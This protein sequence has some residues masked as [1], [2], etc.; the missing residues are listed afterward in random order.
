M[1]ILIAVSLL[2]SSVPALARGGFF[3]SS[4]VFDLDC[5]DLAVFDGDNQFEC[6]SDEDLAVVKR[7]VVGPYLA[8]NSRIRPEWDGAVEFGI[9]PDDST[10]LDYSY[11]RK[12]L[13]RTTRKLVGY[14]VIEM[15]DNSEMGLT[16]RL[17][18]RFNY[19]R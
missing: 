6:R 18:L 9:L 8:S 7:A 16:V 2:L 14:T 3:T 10:N 11:T 4:A 5:Q 1:K 12:L 17:N 13:D 15:Y 19:P